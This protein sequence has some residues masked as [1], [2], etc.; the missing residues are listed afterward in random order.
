MELRTSDGTVIER[1]LFSDVRGHR[2]QRIVVPP[3]ELEQY[4]GHTPRTYFELR[5]QRL[6]K[7]VYG[8]LY[9]ALEPEGDLVLGDEAAAE[10]EVRERQA[11][12]LGL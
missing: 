9:Y 1:P 10:E 8:E 7:Y 2:Y 12:E 5:V 4:F 3:E 11:A 6:R